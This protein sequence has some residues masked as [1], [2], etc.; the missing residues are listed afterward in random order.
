MII[1]G[2]PNFPAGTGAFQDLTG[3]VPQPYSFWGQSG[4]YSVPTSWYI[5]NVNGV[6]YVSPNADFSVPKYVARTN[7]DGVMVFQDLFRNLIDGLLR[8]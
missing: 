1:D 3:G 8:S 7:V 6:N 4:F 5:K 2:N